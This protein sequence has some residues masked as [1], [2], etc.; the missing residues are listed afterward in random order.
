MA[1]LAAETYLAP[2]PVT[3]KDVVVTFTQQEWKLLDLT[4]RTLYQEVVLETSRLLVSLGYPISKTELTCLL[5]PG[6]ELRMVKRALSPST[7]SGGLPRSR[8]WWS[9]QTGRDCC[10]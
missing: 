6:R 1:A 8:Q 2:A 5:H 10:L 9:L 4:Q 3:L 7:S